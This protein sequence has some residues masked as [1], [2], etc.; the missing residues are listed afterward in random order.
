PDT[1]RPLVRRR[2]PVAVPAEHLA[3]APDGRRL[4]VT[5]GLGR[6]EEAWTGLLTAVDL[7]VRRPEV[8]VQAEHRRRRL[9]P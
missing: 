6:N 5:T 4:A 1:G 9:R 2:I 7:D 8:P 3:A